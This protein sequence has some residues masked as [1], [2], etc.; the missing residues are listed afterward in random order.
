MAFETS[1]DS[2]FGF[3]TIFQEDDSVEDLKDTENNK[4]ISVDTGNDN[5]NEIN[6]DIIYIEDPLFMHGTTDNDY[7]IYVKD[8]LMS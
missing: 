1:Y 2:Y 4:D 8:P 6:N 3:E 5:N 7:I